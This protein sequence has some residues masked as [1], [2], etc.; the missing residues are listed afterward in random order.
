M[1]LVEI[2][3]QWYMPSNFYYSKLFDL[4]NNK[5]A[6]IMFLDGDYLLCSSYR[7]SRK[8]WANDYAY[9]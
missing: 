3:P 6:A 4:G 2:N 5:K 9:C 1:A 7:Y 8:A